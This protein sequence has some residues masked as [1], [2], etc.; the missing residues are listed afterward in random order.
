MWKA[1]DVVEFRDYRAFLRA[2]YQT[3]KQE[4]NGFSPRAFSKRA[5][6]RSSNYLKLVMDG[7]R[8]LTPQ[9]APRFARACSLRGQAAAYFCELVAFNQARTLEER[10]RTYAHLSRFKRYRKVYRLDRAHEAYY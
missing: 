3:N 4:R 8:N 6:L 7:D 1:P 10:E 5:Q 2:F 9:M